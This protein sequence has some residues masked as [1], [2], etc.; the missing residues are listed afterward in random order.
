MGAHYYANGDIYDGRFFNNKRVG[1][2]RL[3][4]VNGCEYIGQFIDNES[5]GHGIFTDAEGNRYMSIVVEDELS[6][7]FKNHKPKDIN[8]DSFTSSTNLEPR[9]TKS[10]YFY[11][12]RLF[13]R[14]EI[15]FKNG[16]TYLGNFKGSKRDGIGEMSYVVG[17]EDQPFEI[18][19][20]NGKWK[21]DKRNGFGIM[22]YFDGALFKGIYQNDQKHTGKYTMPDGSV[23]EGRFKNDM[24]NGHG[25]ITYTS[26]TIIEGEF[27]DN[28]L[29][30]RAKLI[31]KTANGE[32]IFKGVLI[33]N[34]IGTQG[35]I[36]YPNGDIYQGSFE[37]GQKHG[38]G[39]YLSANGSKYEGRWE[40]NFRNG[41]GKEYVVGEDEFYEGSFINGRRDGFGR[42]ITHDGK[43]TEAQWS[44]G[45]IMN[46]LRE[47][48]K[49]SLKM[50]R[51]MI[52][53]FVKVKSVSEPDVKI[54]A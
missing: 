19:E 21:R 52:Q 30:G 26:G 25:K 2:S 9:Q 5:D 29:K 51:K 16:N 24:F 35:E 46:V 45:V 10:G 1:K 33:D 31:K 12:L 13:G 44:N 18:G 20:Y 40:D 4:L 8:D 49:V 37:D 15:K 17:T 41:T 22:N 14:G 39:I 32:E 36:T 54:Y 27:Q 38:Y 50:Y 11:Q 6:P 43:V 7:H 53:N 3:R 42:L 23:Y 28:E 48:H 47:S 34:D